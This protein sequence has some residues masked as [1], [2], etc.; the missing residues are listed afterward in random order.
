MFKQHACDVAGRELRAREWSDALPG[1]PYR[2][3]CHGG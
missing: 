2:A 1:R 3:V